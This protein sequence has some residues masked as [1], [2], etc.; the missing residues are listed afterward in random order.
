MAEV[1]FGKTETHFSHQKLSFNFSEIGLVHLHMA[2]HRHT[3][4]APSSLQCARAHRVRAA[5]RK[6]MSGVGCYV[7]GADTNFSE[8]GPAPL[9][10]ADH[11]PAPLPPFSLQG[12]G[13]NRAHAA[14]S[15]RMTWVGC[16]CGWSRAVLEELKLNFQTKE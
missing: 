15:K 5:R 9:H 3:L 8:I 4:S 14:R 12:A 1:N 16:F 6:Q 10:T 11:R 2:R 7:V 13:A